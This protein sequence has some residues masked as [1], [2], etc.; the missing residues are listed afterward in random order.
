MYLR[1]KPVSVVVVL[2]E[3]VRIRS[4][5]LIAEEMTESIY[6]P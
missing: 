1:T 4:L 2:T 3:K 6:R 5:C